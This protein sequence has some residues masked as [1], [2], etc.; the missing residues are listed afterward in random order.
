MSPF[1]EQYILSY[2]NV[3]GNVSHQHGQHK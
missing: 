3:R 2:I 1:K